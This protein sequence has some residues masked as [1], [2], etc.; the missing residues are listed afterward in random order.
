MSGFYML[1]GSLMSEQGLQALQQSLL[2]AGIDS[3]LDDEENE[4]TLTLAATVT[5]REGFAHECIV[6]GDATAEATL[7]ASVQQF[8]S[9]LK[10]QAIAHEF[11]IYDR[12]NRLIHEIGHPG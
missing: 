11:E 3:E 12:Q 4:L 1:A 7:L 2:Q 10:T 5:V 8:S 6:V 9:W